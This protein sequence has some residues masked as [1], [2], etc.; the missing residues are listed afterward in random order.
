MS[1]T[2]ST[3]KP[4]V[5]PFHCPRDLMMKPE[6]M[7]ELATALAVAK[8]RQDVATASKLFH[9]EMLLECPPFGT[10]ARGVDENVQALKRF[11]ASFPDY[12]VALEGYAANAD[13]L[14]CW[15]AVRMTMTGDRFGI[16]P[17][18]RR[19]ALPVFIRFTFKDDLIA[20]EYFHFD[21]SELCAQVGIS[22][23]T[24]RKNL[25][26]SSQTTARRTDASLPSDD[27]V[28]AGT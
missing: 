28:R 19:A 16:V 4:I 21:L 1:F 27:S 24:V 10:R 5:P 8:S 22:A 3:V 13:T 2:P 20:S 9:A 17:N 6:R 12:H 18:G 26:Q 14:V 15:G 7:Y 11:F 25:V 23:D